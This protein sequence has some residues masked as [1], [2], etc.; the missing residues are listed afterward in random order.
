MECIVVSHTSAVRGARAERCSYAAVTWHP[1]DKREQRRVLASCAP[2][3]IAIDFE[4]LARKGFWQGAEGEELHILMG[5]P[6][7]VSRKS[8]LRCHVISKPLPAGAIMRVDAGLY[9]CSPAFATL[10][11][12]EGRSLP[13]V[14]ALVMELLGIYSLP[15]EATL[16][17]AWGGVWPDFTDRHNVEQEHCRCEPAVTMREL[18][19]VAAWA[20][21]R[22]YATFRRAVE[23]ALSGSAS[24]M[25]TVMAG[26]FSIPMRWGGFNLRALPQGGIFL[27]HRIDFSPRAVRMA[28]GIPYAVCDLY[29][30]AAGSDLEYNGGYHE[31]ESV[32]V[33]D[34]QR[35]NGLKGMGVKVLV[36]NRDQMIDIVALEAIAQSIYDDANQ[37]FRY[38]AAGYRARQ[39]ALLNG[40]RAGIGL[41]PV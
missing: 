12:S 3:K 34:G 36:I 5:D 17:I 29:I 15:A 20:T 32:R 16:P 35:N 7:H 8:G 9:C 30:P 38:Q 14:Y 4:E 10:L 19:A 11:Y 26:M 40:L 2:N 18:R 21:G 33:R 22:R 28:S 1:L 39:L 31:Q 41:P 37:R 24:P 25:E 23:Y 6:S 27:N 13:E